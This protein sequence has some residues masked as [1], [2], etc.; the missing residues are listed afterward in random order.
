MSRD[1]G[2]HFVTFAGSGSLDG[3][4]PVAGSQQPSAR[5]PARLLASSFPGLGSTLCVDCVK[6]LHLPRT[7]GH[8]F[9]A[10]LCL[11]QISQSL[12]ER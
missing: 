4:T 2:A 12:E 5:G 9:V 11:E 7:G 1:L 6:A 10:R 8:A 3:S